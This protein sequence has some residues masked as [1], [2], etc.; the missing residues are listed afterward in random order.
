MMLTSVGSVGN[1]VIKYK[2]RK[3]L[4]IRCGKLQIARVMDFML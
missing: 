3:L 1:P 2:L 4:G